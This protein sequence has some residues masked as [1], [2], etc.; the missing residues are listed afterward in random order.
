MRWV[1]ANS[2]SHS[3]S[4]ETSQVTAVASPP[5]FLMPLTVVSSEPVSILCSPSCRVR[6]VQM[7]RAPS[8]AK[9][10]A[11]ACPIPRLAPVTAATF[12][13]SLPLCEMLPLCFHKIGDVSIRIARPGDIPAS[14]FFSRR[15][16]TLWLIFLDVKLDEEVRRKSLLA[17]SRVQDLNAIGEPRRQREP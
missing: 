5:A 12:L 16:H 14:A 1:S 9:S 10:S 7:T 15:R 6:A 3:A 4:E 13:S 11:I 2:F 17:G 8:F